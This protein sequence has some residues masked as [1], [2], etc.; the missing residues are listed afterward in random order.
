LG[1]EVKTVN[2]WTQFIEDKNVHGILFGKEDDNN[3]HRESGLFKL[4]ELPKRSSARNTGGI[5]EEEYKS[6]E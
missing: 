1:I 4:S 6:G 2:D 3:K 5:R